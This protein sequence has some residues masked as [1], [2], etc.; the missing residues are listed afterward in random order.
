[1]SGLG[2]QE[3]ESLNPCETSEERIWFYFFRQDLQDWQPWLNTLRCS[4]K[5]NGVKIFFAFGEEPFCPK[6]F[7]SRWSCPIF[8][9]RWES[10]P[11]FAVFWSS[12]FRVSFSIRLAVFFGRRA[13]NPWPRPIYMN[14]EDKTLLGSLAIKSDNS[15]YRTLRGVGYE[16]G[17]RAGWTLKSSVSNNMLSEKGP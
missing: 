14:L 3:G 13:W 8:F 1:M 4:S 16:P 17:A 10:I 12:L 11:I 5:F 6:A 7:L 9:Y 15:S 2:C